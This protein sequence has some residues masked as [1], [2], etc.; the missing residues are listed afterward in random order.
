MA[1]YNLIKISLI[2]FTIFLVVRNISKLLNLLDYPSN[3]KPHKTATPYTGGICISLCFVIIIFLN[4]YENKTLN[5]ILMYS[6]IVSI[7]GLLDDKF[8]LTVGSKL[9]LLI[10]PIYLLSQHNLLITNIGYYTFF[11]T[12][13]LGSLSLLFTLISSL[14][15][16]NAVNYS[17]GIDGFASCICISSILSL[18]FLIYSQND[19]NREFFIFLLTILIPILI[20]LFFNLSNFKYTKLFLGDSGSLMLGFLISFLIIFSYKNLNIHPSLLIWTISFF[21]YEFISV[22][23]FRILYK[24]KIFK[25]GKDHFHYQILNI[26]NSLKYTNVFGFLLNILLFVFGFFIFVFFGSL[27]SVLS[28]LIM[29]LIFI[30]FKQKLILKNN[31]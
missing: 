20:F 19:F 31:N 16:I 18:I 25:P 28:Y 9:L 27:I 5:F 4:D 1:D 12:I 6:L 10:F 30:K 22:N 11:G 24:K 14:F 13:E 2:S 17:D 29:F 7:I 15:L 21:V 26:T 3:R 8:N 23:L